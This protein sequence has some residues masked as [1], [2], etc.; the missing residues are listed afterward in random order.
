[1]SE[2]HPVVHI[3]TSAPSGT[4]LASYANDA[5]FEA[6][7]GSPAADGDQYYN[8]TL[9]VTRVHANGVWTSAIVDYPKL[10][11]LLQNASIAASVGSSALTIALKTAAGADASATDPIYLAF[12]NATETIGTRNYRAVTA[13]LSIVVSSGSTLGHASAK[14]GW[15]Y[16]Y[17]LDN[18]GTI[19]LAVSASEFDEGSLQSTTAEGGAG[20]AD[21]LTVLY[22]T[23]ARSNV[24]I[25]LIARLRSSQTTAGT[26]AAV[27]TEISLT[28]FQRPPVL[29][30][31]YRSTNQSIATSAP[32]DIVW[33]TV[34]QDR[35][36]AFNNATG[37]FT[38]PESGIYNFDLVLK[39][40][41]TTDFNGTS[42]VW[43]FNL[44]VDGSNFAQIFQ[45]M[46]Q[47]VNVNTI[48]SS[49]ISGIFLNQGQTAKIVATQDSGSGQAFFGTTGTRISIRKVG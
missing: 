36:S 9:H 39:M 44:H 24:P 18:A 31:A 47:S 3:G 12:R 35:Y 43:A 37:V 48:F 16:V 23:T 29:V 11:S 40:Q 7:K 10:S 13:A 14:N 32:T 2:N 41:V 34:V 33:D 28:P 4:N 38:A 26:W 22:S 20:A 42:E 49:G 46:P 5:A 30:V 1:M 25:R 45:F 17:A 27:P 15:I 6:A 21:S 19:E 8:S